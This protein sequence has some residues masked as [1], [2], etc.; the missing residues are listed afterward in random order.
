LQR[1]FK[2]SK[3]NVGFVN[4]AFFSI[5]GGGGDTKQP[6]SSYSQPPVQ[7]QSQVGGGG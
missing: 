1:L 7:S 2:L 4:A 6:T 5:V 3:K